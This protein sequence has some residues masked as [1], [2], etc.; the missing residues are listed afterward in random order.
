MSLYRGV[1][2]CTKIWNGIRNFGLNNEW[3]IG[4]M[5]T[6]YRNGLKEELLING[7]LDI[8][9]VLQVGCVEV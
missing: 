4:R 8:M 1:G 3:K 9:Y 7:R 5:D 6:G 2:V